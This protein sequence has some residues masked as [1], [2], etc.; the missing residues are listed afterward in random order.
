MPDSVRS[1]IRLLVDDALLY[2][3]MKS[4]HDSITIYEDLD[5]LQ[6]WET[7]WQKSYNPEKCEVIRV[8]NKTKV[9]DASYSIHGTIL[10]PK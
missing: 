10:K 6:T 8:T 9:I 5:N 1:N 3:T 4:N 2:R 7:I